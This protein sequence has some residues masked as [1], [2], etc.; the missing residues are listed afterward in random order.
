MGGISRQ[1]NAIEKRFFLLPEGAAV[2]VVGAEVVVELEGGA[3]GVM[4]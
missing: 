4:I 1:S 3:G 2:E